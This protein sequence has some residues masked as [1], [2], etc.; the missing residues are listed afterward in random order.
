M[1]IIFIE[2]AY[3][4]F[5]TD[6]HET[7]NKIL[8]K[9]TIPNKSLLSA[10]C[11]GY[12]ENTLEQLIKDYSIV[13]IFY[14][15]EKQSGKS[16]LVI[17]VSKNGDAVKLRSKKWAK[18]YRELYQ[19]YIYFIDYSRI[20]YQF[21]KGHPFIEYYCQQSSMI[22]QN[23]ASRFS[24]L[25]NRNWK[26]YHKKFNLYEDTFHHDHEIRR[27][28]I[29]RLILED[30][31]NSVFTSFE[32]LIQ[33][34]LEYLE[35]LYSADRTSDIDLNQ[36]INQLLIYLPELQSYFVKKNPSEYF[37]TELFAKVKKAIDE[38][39]I[40]YNIEMFKSLES[41][42]IRFLQLLKLNSTN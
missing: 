3:I 13:Q 9:N 2:S 12:L 19:V 24:L 1:R 34:D 4:Y 25:I 27:V 41:S 5:N 8:W 42:R 26:K 28:K 17:S 14:K 29:E 23:E 16:H 30:S 11:N 33:Y 38:D 31:N 22:Y 7:N 10:L 32:E 20:E 35:E 21:S 6:Q 18:E 40:I 36:R 15:Q 37:I 39:D